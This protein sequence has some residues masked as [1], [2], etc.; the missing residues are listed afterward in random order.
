SADTREI[1]ITYLRSTLFS[2]DSECH[3]YHMG[4]TQAVGDFFQF[5]VD[6]SEFSPEDVIITF[7]NNQGTRKLAGTIT[8]T[9]TNTFPH[10]C[11]P[12]SSVDPIFVTVTMGSSMVQTVRDDIS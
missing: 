11:K 3:S 9:V 4:K 12:P 6:V 1:I 10:K 5:T 2:E 7:Y 8:I